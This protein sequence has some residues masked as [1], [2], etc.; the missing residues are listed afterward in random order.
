M[1][2]SSSHQSRPSAHLGFHRYFLTILAAGRRPVFASPPIVGPVQSHLLRTASEHRFAVLAYCFLPDH[3]HA[4]VEGKSE[5]SDF[6]RF[7]RSFKQLSSRWYRGYRAASLWGAGYYDRV[8]T[9]EE[10]RVLIGRYM[11]ENRA[12][13]GLA[14]P[15]SCPFSDS[16][17]F[18][19]KDVI[20]FVGD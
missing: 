3:L 2:S 17:R 12:R 18:V 6:Q 20:E 19:I 11:V 10:A 8:V 5:S 7:V 16:E 1:A 14:M 13:N 4:L 9:D 15:H